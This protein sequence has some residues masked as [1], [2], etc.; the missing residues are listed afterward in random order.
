MR[1]R[2]RPKK[3]ANRG[4]V[5]PE[6]SDI[7]VE[8]TIAAT[9]AIAKDKIDEPTLQVVE[10]GPSAISVE[11]PK[12]V[13]VEPSDERK[14]TM[15]S[16]FPSKELTQFVR[17]EDIPQPKTSEELAKELTLNETILEQ[18]VAQVGGT[19]GNIVDI[20]E[21]PPPEEV[22]R[23][24]VA[25]KTLE[26]RS[27]A[28]EIAFPD[29]LQDSV[30]SSLKYLNTKREKHTVRRESGSYVELIK[31]R[32]KLKRAVAV[33][34]EWGTAT[35]MAKERAASLLVITLSLFY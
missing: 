35:A 26:E 34:R 19:V 16:S 12:D 32:M 28:M 29:F 10:G 11:V 22:V 18:I 5:V 30:V 8:K 4:V 27:Q 3:K 7:S 14:E 25:T 2:A 23:P 17:S 6:S 33:K 9:V 13:A 15:S 31:N 21:P 1:T 24:K 20:L